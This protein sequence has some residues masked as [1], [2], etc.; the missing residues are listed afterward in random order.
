MTK[1]N[2]NDQYSRFD[3]KYCKSLVAIQLQCLQ[4]HKLNIYSTCMY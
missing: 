1:K 4:G 3:I 2:Y